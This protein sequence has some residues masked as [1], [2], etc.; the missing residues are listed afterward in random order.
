MNTSELNATT[1]AFGLSV[2][3]TS[4]LSALLVVAKELNEG[5]LNFMKHVTMHHWVTHGIFNIIV[6]LLVGF[7]LSK[8]N[9]PRAG[10]S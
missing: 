8:A 5:L 7:V 2:A 4:I 9:G 1:R 3:V 10:H 6:F